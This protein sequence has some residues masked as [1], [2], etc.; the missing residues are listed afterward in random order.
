[1]STTKR[2]MRRSIFGK[3]SYSNSYVK[4]IRTYVADV[5]RLSWHMNSFHGLN[6]TGIPVQLEVNGSYTLNSPI[7]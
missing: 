7:D 3:R 4:K 1:M 2:V 5:D 6:D